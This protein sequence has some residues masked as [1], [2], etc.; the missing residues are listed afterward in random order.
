[1]KNFKTIMVIVFCCCLLGSSFVQASTADSSWSYKNYNNV[2]YSGD[3]YKDTAGNVYCYPKKGGKVCV[4][5]QKMSDLSKAYSKKVTLKRGTQYTIVN[6]A[7]ANCYVRLKF[8]AATIDS[9]VN[10]GN[11]SPDASRDYTVVGK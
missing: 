2:A 8:N 11:W 6:Q 9:T 4:T 3:R 1:M 7:K 10:S 5:V